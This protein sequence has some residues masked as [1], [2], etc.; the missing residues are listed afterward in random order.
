MRPLQWRLMSDDL[1]RVELYTD[2]A[3]SGNPGPG[4]WA[5]ILR[6]VDSGKEVE[7]SDGERAT[8]NN[9]M[10]L[11]AVING[12]NRLKKRSRVDLFSDSQYGVHGL[13]EWMDQWKAK[14][15][16][17]G[18]NQPVLNLDMWQQLDEL[19]GKHEINANWVKAHAEHPENERC[20][21][22]AVAA[23]ERFK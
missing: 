3:C 12:L 1:P 5:F 22:L 18:R 2:G 17:R 21:E 10:E 8:T 16:T 7:G 20:D 15:W 11:K 14:G 23:V 4:G 19:R 13:Q 9:K 6:H